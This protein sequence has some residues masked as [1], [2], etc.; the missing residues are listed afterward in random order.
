MCIIAYDVFQS[1]YSHQHVSAACWWEYGEMKYIIKQRSAFW[2]GY[3]YIM[4]L[5]N[6][7]KTGHIKINVNQFHLKFSF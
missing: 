3:L 6:A 2:F 7:G 1:Q 5:I 4:D